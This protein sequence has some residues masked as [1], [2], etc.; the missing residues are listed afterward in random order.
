MKRYDNSLFFHAKIAMKRTIK[1]AERF[2]FF[3]QLDNFFRKR[4]FFLFYI[5]SKE[6]TDLCVFEGTDDTGIRLEPTVESR[7]V[8][9][10][11]YT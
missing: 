10:K 7:C 5:L 6:D 1:N 8:D 3:Y 4:D 9:I 2:C 11:M